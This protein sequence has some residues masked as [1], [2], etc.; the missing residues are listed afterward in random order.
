MYEIV[1]ALRPTALAEIICDIEELGDRATPSQIHFKD[2]CV[3]ALAANVGEDEARLMIEGVL[4]H[5]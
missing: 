2:L 5:A 3:T 1:E 4:V